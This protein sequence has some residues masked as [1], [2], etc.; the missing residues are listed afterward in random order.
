MPLI[1]VTVSDEEDIAV[2][3]LA[4]KK[5]VSKGALLTMLLRDELRNIVRL[6]TERRWEVRRKALDADPALAAPVDAA[7]EAP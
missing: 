5:S 7:A 4:G 2:A 3:W 1:A 6:Y